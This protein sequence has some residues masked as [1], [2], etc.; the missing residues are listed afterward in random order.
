MTAH[1][2]FARQR[3]R[4]AEEL[5]AEILVWGG[6]SRPQ[7]NPMAALHRGWIDLKAGLTVGR[8]NETRVVL[9][10]S[11]RGE[12]FAQQR[13]QTAMQRPLPASVLERL[14]RQVATIESVCDQLEQLAEC[15]DETLVLQLFPDGQSARSAA[16]HLAHDRVAHSQVQVTAI[17]PDS[18]YACQCQ[19]QRVLECAS[20]GALSGGAIGGLMGIVVVVRLLLTGEVGAAFDVM[21]AAI[22]LAGGVGCLFGAVVG[23][24]IGQGVTGEDAYVYAESTQR[25]GAVLAVAT[26]RADSVRVQAYLQQS[27]LARRT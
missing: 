4:F 26:Q 13:Y 24:V 20:A 14:E 15:G 8:A 19:R 3:T 22:A 23:V 10:E 12:R 9:M 16:L 17:Q 6:A 2:Y 25:G 18:P 21:V 7:R 27:R 11:L 1:R 5:R